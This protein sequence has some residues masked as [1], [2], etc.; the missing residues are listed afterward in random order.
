MV[1][2]QKEGVVISVNININKGEK[3]KPIVGYSELIVGYGLK[4]D[5][6]S[7]SWHRQVSLLGIESIEKMRRLGLNVSYGDFAEN[8][9]TAGINLTDLYPGCCLKIGDKAVL[10]IT[11]L[12]KICHNRCDIYY[13]VG[14][15]IMPK[16]GVFAEVVVG[17]RIKSGDKI[18]IIN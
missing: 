17:G 3:K 7:G 9:T 16:E 11:Q 8:I 12:G 6:H 10:K 5:G 13:Q 1:L 14:D 4:G 2:Y 15:C 18:V